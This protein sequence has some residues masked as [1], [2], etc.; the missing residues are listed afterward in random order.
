[1][2][3][4]AGIAIRKY[5]PKNVNCTSAACTYVRSKIAFRCGMRMSLSAVRKPHM[6]NSVVTAA[7]GR[8]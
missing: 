5:A 1:M 2:T 7:N 8:R 6:K 4:S 3:R